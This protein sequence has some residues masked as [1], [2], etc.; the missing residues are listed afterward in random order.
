M[1]WHRPSQPEAELG[2]TA[3]AAAPA[4]N[5]R[6][7][8][9]AQPDFAASDFLPPDIVE[10]RDL[11]RKIVREELMPLE[12]QYLTSP[13]QAYGLFAID[14]LREAF[15]KEVADRLIKISR[16]T[17]FWYLTVPE[18]HGGL[19]LS[20]LA[21]VAIMQ[22]FNYCAVPFPFANVANILYEC[23]PDQVEKY[24]RPVIEGEK[25]TCFAQTEPDAGSDPG[26][27]MRTTAVRSGDDWIIN[28]TKTW[29]SNAADADFMMVQ[30]VTDPV[31][32]Q[33]GGIT[34]FLVDKNHPGVTVGPGLDTWLGPRS[35]QNS[36]TFNDCRVGPEAV[37]GEVGKGFSLG[38]QWLMIHDRLMRGPYALGKMQRAIDMSIEWAKQRSTFGKFIAERQAIQWKLV[39]MYVDIQ[40]LQA[41]TYAVAARADAGDDVRTEAALV[42]L[43][44]GDW[45]ARVLDAAIQVHGGTGEATDLPLTLFYRYLRHAQIGG[46]T[47]EIQRVMIARKLLA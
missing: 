42:K 39:D 35:A 45:G 37:L 13:K 8:M 16:D 2:T 7:P 34:M 46:G 26:G 15:G 30:A 1:S 27:M 36:I 40:A 33:R 29:I 4:A 24:L 20:I 31:K 28:G 18:E 19:G 22:E 23:R 43:C 9:N 12:V 41:M 47:S 32:R 17:G 14:N 25:T 38:Q 6:K 44:S 3:N 10:F 21:K 5:R 11:A